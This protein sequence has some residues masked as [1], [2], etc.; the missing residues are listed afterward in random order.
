VT[1]KFRSNDRNKLVGHFLEWAMNESGGSLA[2]E[3]FSF[4]V[5]GLLSLH[6]DCSRMTYALSAS[7]VS[8]SSHGEE[9]TEVDSSALARAELVWE[10]SRG[11]LM[12]PESILQSVADMKKKVKEAEGANELGQQHGEPAQAS[13]S[14]S[15]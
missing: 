7:E 15:S 10:M 1:V 3:A 5:C 14:S 8:T 12:D 2:E 11:G 6:F 13:R 4:P 9:G